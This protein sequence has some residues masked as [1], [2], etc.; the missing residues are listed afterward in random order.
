VPAARKAVA[1]A[2]AVRISVGPGL[3]ALAFSDGFID[4]DCAADRTGRCRRTGV[5]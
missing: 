4:T 5:R 2:D 1:H 3:V